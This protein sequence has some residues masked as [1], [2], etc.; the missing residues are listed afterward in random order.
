MV[1]EDSGQVVRC[2]LFSTQSHFL[3]LIPGRIELINRGFE[4]KVVLRW[5]GE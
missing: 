1:A 5:E 4:I 3:P 2:D